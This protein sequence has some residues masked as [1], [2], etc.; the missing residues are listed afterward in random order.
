MN[1]SSSFT[2]PTICGFGVLPA[3]QVSVRPRR[4]VSNKSFK[5][6]NRL[7]LILSPLSLYTSN[8]ATCDVTH[9][10]RHGTPDDERR[11]NSSRRDHFQ[12]DPSRP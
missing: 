1:Y 12:F 3:T 4:G 2:V 7:E 9:K 11:L 6:K 10:L 5:K 8:R